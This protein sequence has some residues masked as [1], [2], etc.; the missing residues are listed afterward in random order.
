MN[1]I[2]L[3]LTQAL[4]HIDE[5]AAWTTPLD[6]G[7]KTLEQPC[8]A[9][10]PH[11]LFLIDQLCVPGGGERVLLNMVR[12][13]PEDRFRCS[14]ATIKL[15]S[16]VALFRQIPCPVHLL[17]LRR[18]YGWSGL[19]AALKLREIIRSQDVKI[20]HT[21]FET[22]DI[23]GGLVAKLSGCPVLISSRRDMGILRSGK[24][25]VAY[26]V[27]APLFDRVLTVSDEVRNFC[28]QEDR[29]DP[30]K[31]VTVYSGIDLDRIQTSNGSGTLRPDLGL[32][33]SWVP[34]LT[35]EESGEVRATH[36]VTAVGHIRR[37]K[38]FDTFIRAAA[39]VRREFPTAE[40]LIIGR[41]HPNE[42]EYLPELQE[43]A[44]S[45]G[46]SDAVRFPGA[47]KNVVPVLQMSD[48]YCMPSR[49][50]GFSNALVEAMACS[51]P[52]VA[53]RVGGNAEAVED[54]VSGFLV[55][56]EDPESMA[57]RI[58]RLLRRPEEARRMGEAGR[59]RV[60]EKFT[61]Q[62]MMANL[63]AIYDGLL[64]AASRR[65]AA[66]WARS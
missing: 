65:S 16:S 55:P 28:V 41:A 47:S 44:R 57:D 61:V 13:L 24:H 52:C 18:T 9:P 36:R 35:K 59:R 51:L 53:T 38:G 48:V 2:P 42:P 50:E 45:L 54:T 60:V 31:V 46:L 33:P 64:S 3:M 66:G 5:F 29:L 30:R 17:P 63:V 8:A 14:L 10:R 20:V 4:A 21:F 12:L 7:V 15:D 49:S 40:F 26:R 32:A 39:I 27:M 6:A 19:Q 58:M 22:S 23:W 62:A 43:L 37:V 1:S 11:I 56:P 34:L 25:R